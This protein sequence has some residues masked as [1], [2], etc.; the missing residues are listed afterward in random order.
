MGA[1]R[2]GQSA[3][4]TNPWPPRGIAQGDPQPSAGVDALTAEGYRVSFDV[5]PMPEDADEWQDHLN[6]SAVVRMFNELR[7]AYVAARLAPDWPRYVRRGSLAV[8]V[9]ELHVQYDSEGWMHERYVGGTRIS[10]RRG[11]AG[12][13]EQHLVEATTGRSLAQAW[14]VQLLVGADGKVIDWPEWY[15]ETI[16]TVEGAPARELDGARQPWGPPL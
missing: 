7:M 16:A 13:H 6:N 2:R 10:Q 11:K 4:W 15:W 8:V 12:I 1:E 3:D 5:T 14:L 9:R